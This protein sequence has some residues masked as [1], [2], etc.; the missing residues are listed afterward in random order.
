MTNTSLINLETLIDD[1]K[2]FEILRQLRW[3]QGI[4]CYDC[5][6]TEIVK[7]GFDETQSSRQRYQCKAC[8]KRFDDLSYTIF[9][10]HHQPLQTWIVCLYFLGLNLSNHQIA[11]ELDLNKDD[12]QAMTSQLRSG[13]VAKKP[14]VT[15][16]GEVE[17]D[18]AYV[19]AGHK[20]R[21]EAVKKKRERVAV[22]V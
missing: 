10:G 3:P 6:S 9:A 14:V 15:L 11:H 4:D 19:I 17:C 12:V 5:Q 21:P 16:Q 18:E 13:I 1:A 2:C 8:H 22:V 7:R 20:G